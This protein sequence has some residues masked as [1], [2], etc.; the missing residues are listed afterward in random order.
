ML[1]VVG[2]DPVEQR[3]QRD[4]DGVERVLEDPVCAACGT[5]CSGCSRAAGTPSV[6]MTVGFRI[7]QRPTG[8]RFVWW[9]AAM[10]G[11]NQSSNVSAGEL[12]RTYGAERTGATRLP[13]AT[14]VSGLLLSRGC[15][16]RLTGAVQ[17]EPLQPSAR[18]AGLFEG[19]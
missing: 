5:P 6:A 15:C 11:V 10:R 1:G 9:Q 8:E 4:I 3:G 14:A 19:R 16:S 17:T 7:L 18:V 13:T 12:T 2:L